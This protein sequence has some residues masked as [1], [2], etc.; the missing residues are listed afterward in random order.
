MAYIPYTVFIIFFLFE[1]ANNIEKRHTKQSN[2]GRCNCRNMPITNRMKLYMY[3]SML[4]LYVNTTTELSD[5]FHTHKKTEV[6]IHTVAVNHRRRIETEAKAKVVT[7]LWGTKFIQFLAALNVFP[8]LIWKI[9]FN[10][11]FSFKSN[12]AKQLARP[13][14]L[15]PSFIYAV[16]T[17]TV[18]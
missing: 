6:G 5:T 7:S 14:L 16:N 1:A 4:I 15:S 10:S 3:K 2:L 9:K 13:L 12:E 17:L 11:S 8:R 18:F